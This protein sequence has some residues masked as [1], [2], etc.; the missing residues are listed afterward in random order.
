MNQALKVLGIVVLALVA[1]GVLLGGGF[2]IGRAAN[3]RQEFV[4]YPRAL[5]A[6]GAFG[7]GMMQG[8]DEQTTL[9]VAGWLSLSIPLVGLRSIVTMCGE[10]LTRCSTRYRS[11]L[12]AR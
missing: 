12:N 8:W 5:A 10:M 11:L 6:D 1:V 7:P 9:R 3:A 2:L 4:A